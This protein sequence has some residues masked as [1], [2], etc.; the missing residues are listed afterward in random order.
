MTR[1]SATVVLVPMDGAEA[2][3]VARWRY[4]APFDFYDGSEAEVAVMLDPANGY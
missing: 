3:S 2:A 1:P 4:P